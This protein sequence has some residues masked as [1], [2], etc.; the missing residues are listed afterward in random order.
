MD[1]IFRSAGRMTGKA[2]QTQ[3]YKTVREKAIEYTNEGIEA[4]KTAVK[5]AAAKQKF[6]SHLFILGRNVYKLVSNGESP[7]G[8][9]QINALISVLKEIE[10]EIA[11]LEK[12]KDAGK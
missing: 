10:N 3:T 11:A 4:A 1:S 12:E 2:M 7:A 9:K 5:T 6:K 8:N